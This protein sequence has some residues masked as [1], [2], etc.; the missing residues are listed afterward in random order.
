MVERVARESGS[1]ASAVRI[2]DAILPQVTTVAELEALPD[3][4]AVSWSGP[5]GGGLLLHVVKPHGALRCDS[6]F[7]SFEQAIAE[8]GSLTVVWQP[9][10]TE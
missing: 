2:L 5:S 6:W 3:Y 10:V 9:E 8:L 7:G 4:S 1:T